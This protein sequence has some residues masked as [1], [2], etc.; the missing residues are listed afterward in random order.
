MI[1]KLILRLLLFFILLHIGYVNLVEYQFEFPRYLLGMV[2]IIAAIL[3]LL[4]NK[5][6][7]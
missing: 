7:K 1:L 5:F 4:T 3:L 6:D 2:C